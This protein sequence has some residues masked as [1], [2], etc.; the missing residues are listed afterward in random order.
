MRPAALSV[1]RGRGHL[2][3]DPARREDLVGVPGTRD[4][5]LREPVHVDTV[6]DVLP[7]V[8]AAG[9]GVK[10]V[11]HLLVVDLEEGTLTEELHKLA[12]LLL[13]SVDVTKEV[14]KASRDDAS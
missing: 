12:K 6:F 14:L 2:S 7:K 4:T 9:G 11:V 13:L 5:D 3:V 8:Q 10:E 1:H